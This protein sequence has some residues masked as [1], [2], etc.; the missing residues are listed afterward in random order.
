MKFKIEAAQRLKASAWWDTLSDA[1]RKA[2]KKLHPNST[3]GTPEA[4][5]KEYNKAAI[6]NAQREL[7]SARKAA[8]QYA[9]KGDRTE[10]EWS[11]FDRSQDRIR[12]A[13]RKLR[14][15]KGK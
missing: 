12:N 15:L 7:E 11:E 9:G 14:K 13:A 3:L 2:Y 1:A 5:K 6:E 4:D 8:E 10:A